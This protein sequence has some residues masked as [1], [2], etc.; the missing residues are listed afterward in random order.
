MITFR[1][2]IIVFSYSNKLMTMNQ[3]FVLS[4]N[5]IME[6]YCKEE[7]ALLNGVVDEPF[8]CPVC[9]CGYLQKMDSQNI[10]TCTRCSVHLCTSL[11]LIELN[12]VLHEAL[13]EHSSRCNS[14]PQFT[15]INEPNSSGLF[16]IC[17]NCSSFNA[18]C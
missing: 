7:E 14:T 15:V 17:Q 5:W 2:Y 3:F 8:L 10:I 11:T 12:S 18:L 6:E 4:V 13:V 9:Q 16:I 1:S